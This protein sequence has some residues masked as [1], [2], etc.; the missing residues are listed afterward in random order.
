MNTTP[1]TSVDESK[2]IEKYRNFIMK[3]VYEFCIRICIDNTHPFYEDLITEAQ[4]A[5]ID[6]CRNQNVSSLNLSAW[7]HACLKRKMKTQMRVAFWYFSNMGGYNTKKIDT[8]RSYT[9]TDFESDND[10]EFESRV[11]SYSI[12]DTKIDLESFYMILPDYLRTTLRYISAG[13]TDTIIAEK[14]DVSIRVIGKW[15]RKAGNLYLDYLA[16]AM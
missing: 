5:F 14:L 13:Y 8:S 6:E 15:R 11:P 2:L 9:F 10:A 12:D 7:Q 1:L 4:I 3:E 16:S